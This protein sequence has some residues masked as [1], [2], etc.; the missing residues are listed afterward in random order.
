MDE[1]KQK[2]LKDLIPLLR[3]LERQGFLVSFF[4]S[5]GRVRW[6]KTE[7]EFPME[8]SEIEHDLLS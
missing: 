5:D 1:R 7:K 8:A 2:F 6:R 3:S 4:G